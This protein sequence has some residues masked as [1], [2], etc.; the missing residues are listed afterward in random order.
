MPLTQQALSQMRAD[1]TG[2]ACDEPV[3]HVRQNIGTTRGPPE[4][5][6][7]AS[8]DARATDRS[9]APANSMAWFGRHVGDSTVPPSRAGA[10]AEL[11]EPRRFLSTVPWGGI[12]QLIR[13]DV[14]AQTFPHV[15]G[16]DQYIAVLDTGID[17]TQPFL[18]GGFGDGFKVAGGYDFVDNDPDPIDT[19]GHG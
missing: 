7:G 19:F 17:Y 4:A 13:Q 11:L 15:T 18:G 14:A 5:Y 2:P 1:E 10:A 12:P 8:G 9:G 3:C 6:N 16:K